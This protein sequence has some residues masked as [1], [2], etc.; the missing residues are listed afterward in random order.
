[1]SL[2]NIV[3]VRG[4]D[5]EIFT[6]QVAEG[7]PLQILCQADRRTA[8][9]GIQFGNMATLNLQPNGRE[10]SSGNKNS[11]RQTQ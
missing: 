10:A 4:R 11:L 7:I 6:S 3:R 8:L 5:L 1:V 9:A 2:I